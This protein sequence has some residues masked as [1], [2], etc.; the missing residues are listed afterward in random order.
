MSNNN[1]ALDG[2]NLSIDIETHPFN[3][4]PE[5]RNI[6]SAQAISFVKTGR[7]IDFSLI[8]I[9]IGPADSDLAWLKNNF[10]RLKSVVVRMDKEP[11]FNIPVSQEHSELSFGISVDDLVA[12]WSL[13]QEIK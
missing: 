2:T 7:K 5:V 4:K 10:Y 13:T 3:G 8:G 11:I 6:V 12:E 1:L 9:L